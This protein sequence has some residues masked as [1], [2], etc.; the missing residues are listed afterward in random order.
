MIF[1][2][3]LVG[4]DLPLSPAEYR[5]L[6]TVFSTEPGMHF[7][8]CVFTFAIFLPIYYTVESNKSRYICVI[9]FNGGNIEQIL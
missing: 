8:V 3:L 1:G 6:G 5:Y 2:M 7:A 9:K 4:M